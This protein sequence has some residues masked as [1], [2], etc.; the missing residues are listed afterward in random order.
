M[1]LCDNGNEF[2]V[3]TGEDKF[4][5]GKFGDDGGKEFTK[6]MVGSAKLCKPT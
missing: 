2:S 5:E 3:L 6:I 4:G 1:H